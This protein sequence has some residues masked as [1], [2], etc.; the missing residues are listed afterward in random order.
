MPAWKPRLVIPLAL[1]SYPPMTVRAQSPS[2]STQEAAHDDHGERPA[3]ERLHRYARQTIVLEDFAA[4][5]YILDIGGGGEGI[6]GQLKPAQVVAI[7]LSARELLGAPAG[8]LKNVASNF[9]S[10]SG[11]PTAERRTF[12]ST[13]SRSADFERFEE[14]M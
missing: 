1:V 4:D 5:G 12:H 9:S 7:D 14:P 8:P 6:I 10:T 13:P 11:E 2:P 3:P